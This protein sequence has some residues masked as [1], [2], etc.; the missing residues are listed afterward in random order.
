MKSSLRSPLTGLV[1]VDEFAIGG[2]EEGKK[3]EVKGK[4]N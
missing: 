4:K 1:H 2:P 3:V